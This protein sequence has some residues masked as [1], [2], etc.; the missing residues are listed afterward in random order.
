LILKRDTHIDSLLE[1]LKEPRVAKVMDAVFAGTKSKVLLESDDRRY[2]VDLGLVVPDE[3]KKLRPAN[4]LYGEVMSRIITD[5]IAFQ[6]NDSLAKTKWTDGKVIFMTDLLLEF[7][8]FWRHGSNSFPLRKKTAS[9]LKLDCRRNI[10]LS[11]L[12]AGSICPPR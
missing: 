5:Q 12:V 10:H 8:K 2:C 6:L 3:N 9:D 4:P 7:Q 11:A 1:R